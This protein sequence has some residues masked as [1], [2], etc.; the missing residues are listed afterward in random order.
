[1][2]LSFDASVKLKKNDIKGYINHVFRKSDDRNLRHSNKEIN[3]DLTKNNIDYNLSSDGYGKT[4]EERLNNRLKDYSSL[5]KTGKVRQLRSDAVLARAFVLQPSSDFFE[6]K[7]DKEKSELLDKF[8]RDAM[9]FLLARF[10]GRKNLLGMSGHLD[11][12]NP[13]LQ[14]AFCMM[15]EDGRLSQK[16][17]FSG[18]KQLA[19]MHRDFRSY[20]NDRGWDFEIENKHEDTKHYSDSDYKRNAKAIESAR[21]EYT[22]RKRSYNKEFDDLSAEREKIEHERNQLAEERRLFEENQRR[23]NEA[24]R[25]RKRALDEEVKEEY[26]K[27]R[28]TAEIDALTSFRS[29]LMNLYENTYLAE[30]ITREFN[31]AIN[32]PFLG[33]QPVGLGGSK[34][35]EEEK[36]QSVN[37][38]VKR[39]SE[40]LDLEL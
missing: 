4:F 27:A 33:F 34:A 8:T 13:H 32:R 15:T 24:L 2:H 11:E 1:M 7:T 14:C 12:T 10:G 30:R 20:M 23:E 16:D 25:A 26:Q 35:L 18:P 19:A 5:T 31:K 29:V 40:G 38:Q 39:A 9:P 37:E 36:K 17:F 22:A 21:D 3:P 28:E 6:G